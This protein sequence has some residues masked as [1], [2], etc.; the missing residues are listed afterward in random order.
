M[1]SKI[2]VAVDLRKESR[3][4]IKKAAS[5][6]KP[7]GKIVLL[8]AIEPSE[9][10][11]FSAFPFGVL[12]DVKDAEN[13]VLVSAQDRLNKLA[14]SFDIPEKMIKIEVGKASRVIKSVA[15]ELKSD[16]IVIGTHGQKGYELLLGTTASGVLHGSPCDVLTVQMRKP[17]K[18]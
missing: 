18:S 14:K 2:L 6:L 8:H 17:P 11:L 4:I 12:A 3:K 5:L 10:G 16:L 15:L 7:N 1:Y 9:F 13:K